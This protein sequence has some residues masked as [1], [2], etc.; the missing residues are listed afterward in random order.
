MDNKII[1]QVAHQPKPV[2]IEQAENDV[3]IIE[4][5]RYSADFFR[6]HAYPNDKYLYAIR[7]DGDVVS[8][9][10]IHNANDA[11]HFFDQVFLADAKEE[12]N[13]EIW[14]GNP[15]PTDGGA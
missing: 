13:H 7:R 14:Q 3:I 1:Q 9:T 4:G 10:A 12:I 8:L 5:V 15:A 2:T 6:V 11:E